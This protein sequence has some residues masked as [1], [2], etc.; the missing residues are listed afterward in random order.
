MMYLLSQQILDT[1]RK[2]LEQGIER[3][4]EK[5]YSGLEQED[6]DNYSVYTGSGGKNLENK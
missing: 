1:F 3:L 2:P 4:L 5:L 6:D